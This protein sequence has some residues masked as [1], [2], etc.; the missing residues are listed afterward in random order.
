MIWR[1]RCWGDPVGESFVYGVAAATAVLR[2]ASSF[3]PLFS[4]G[5]SCTVGI[6]PVAGRDACWD[7]RTPE[8]RVR[9]FN[10][11]RSVKTDVFLW[12]S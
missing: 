12:N 3:T 9:W 11:G 1:V 10:L 6:R 4:V 5:I 7:V 2:T 8:N